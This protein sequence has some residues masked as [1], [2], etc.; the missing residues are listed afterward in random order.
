MKKLLAGL[1]AS[2]TLFA[3]A[4]VQAVDGVTARQLLIGQSITLEGGKNDYGTAVLAGMQTYLS[5]VNARGGVNGR[6]V[7]LKTLDDDNKS[8]KA[9]TNAR[10]LVE[11]DKVF[12][13]FGSIEGGPSVAVMKAANEL[14][15]PFFGPMAGS[16][17]LRR[18]YQPLVF[19]VRAEHREEFFALLSHAHSLGMRKVAFLRSDSETGEQHLANVRL[20]CQRLGMTLV[21]DLPFKSDI[22]DAQL[23]SMVT[24]LEQA[25]AQMVFNHGGVGIYEKL[26]RKAKDKAMQTAFYAVNSA[27]AQLVK[28][29][30][31]L[32]H[33]M[34]FTQVVPSPWERKSAITRE[35]Q[36]EFARFMPGQ[37]FSYGSLEGYVTAKALVAAL[38]LAGTSP[39]REGFVTAL[40]GTTLDLNGLRA[41]YDSSNHQGLA[42]VDIS[43]VTRE[44]KFR[45]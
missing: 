3:G 28:R 39:S 2:A 24:Q 23:G 16:P 40:E 7:V 12:A 43:M 21:A 26:I 11:K 33:G 8:A 6:Q 1:I 10:Q 5:A 17:T 13:L 27:S 44:S 30:G 36:T 37:E 31:E 35:Y 15:V 20:I 14:K 9:E 29:L 32:S 45:H 18:P 19:P 41:S 42:F 22:T 25:G 38:R 4:P 34:V